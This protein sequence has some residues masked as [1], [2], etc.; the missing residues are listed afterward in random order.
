MSNRGY[1]RAA[2]QHIAR[3]FPRSASVAVARTRASMTGARALGL[4][5][6]IPPPHPLVWG[7]LAAGFLAWYLMNKTK[8]FVLLGDWT[9]YQQCQYESEVGWVGPLPKETCYVNQGGLTPSWGTVPA[10]VQEIHTMNQYLFFG[11]YRFSTQKTYSRTTTA[12]T[13]PPLYKTQP[14]VIDSGNSKTWEHALPAWG[15]S[16]I[17]SALPVAGTGNT[18]P[19]SAA[20][21]WTVV[22]WY[23]NTE[24][25]NSGY[26]VVSDADTDTDTLDKEIAVVSTL[27]YQQVTRLTEGVYVRQPVSPPNTKEAKVIYVGLL[28]QLRILQAF[29][30]YVDMLD[31]LYRAIP[32]VFRRKYKG[33]ER[34]TGVWDH[35]AFVVWHEWANVDIA[36]AIWNLINN[37]A[38]DAAIG[39]LSGAAGRALGK[40]TQGPGTAGPWDTP[41]RGSLTELGID[42]TSVPSVGFNKFVR[43]AKKQHLSIY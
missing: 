41:P 27:H 29:T 12:A 33:N 43:K 40:A 34:G 28:N 16:V 36:Q 38:T 37:Q 15:Y 2:A 10:F 26:E 20:I 14:Q 1:P 11:S 32:K 24:G 19:G 35:K 23:S 5:G 4:L 39:S 13:L 21:P 8:S 17:P 30:E 3:N 25:R 42:G 31:A 22:P 9:L 6:R 18:F 7:A